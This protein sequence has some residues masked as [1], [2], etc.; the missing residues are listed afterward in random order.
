MD[1]LNL[2]HIIIPHYSKYCLRTSSL[3]ITKS[4]RNAVLASPDLLNHRIP[5]DFIRIWQLVK[6]NCYL[7]YT[8]GQIRSV[9]LLSHVQLVAT[10]WAAARQSSPSITNSRSLLKLMSIKSVRPASHLILC[11]PLLLPPS[12]FP[13]IRVFS[14]ESV[15]IRWPKYWSFSFSISPSNDCSNQ[16]SWNTAF[17]ISLEF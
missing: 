2:K 14:S 6:P 9:Q 17:I 7:L 16:S 1:I 5:G 8:F 11:C 10:P 12:I 3:G 4:V 15:H 13:S